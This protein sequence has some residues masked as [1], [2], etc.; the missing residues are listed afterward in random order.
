MYSL[1]GLV[2]FSIIFLVCAYLYAHCYPS[3]DLDFL[4]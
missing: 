2:K 4:P 3:F 1:S